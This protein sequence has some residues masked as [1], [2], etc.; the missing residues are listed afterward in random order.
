[1]PKQR[2][3]LPRFNPVS[4]RSSLQFQFAVQVPDQLR[5]TEERNDFTLVFVWRKEFQFHAGDRNG[6]TWTTADQ[7]KEK[8]L[9]GPVVRA[10]LGA[11]RKSPARHFPNKKNLRPADS[12]TRGSEQAR[13]NSVRTD[14]LE[15]AGECLNDFEFVVTFCCNFAP[16][17]QKTLYLWDGASEGIRTLDTHVGNVMLYQAELRSRPVRRAYT[18]NF[19]AERK[20]CFLK[21]GPPADAVRSVDF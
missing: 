5:L 9:L 21:N 6:G 10:G 20:P 1:M 19:P 12:T 4:F 13:H 7:V 3:P 8:W 11:E 15:Q 17:G 16:C 2:H 14:I 18:T